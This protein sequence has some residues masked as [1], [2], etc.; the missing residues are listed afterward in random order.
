MIPALLSLFAFAAG[1]LSS[2]V[3]VFILIFPPV[4]IFLCPECRRHADIR[5]SA[6]AAKQTFLLLNRTRKRHEEFCCALQYGAVR[7][8]GLF[9]QRRA[10]T[11]PKALLFIDGSFIYLIIEQQYAA[12]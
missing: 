10:G 9:I 4:V 11:I 1:L 3:T 7:K 12:C 2:A 5:F 8:E 6:A